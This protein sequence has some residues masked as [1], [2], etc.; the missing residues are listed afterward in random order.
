VRIHHLRVQ[1]FGPFA[2]EVE[3]DLD[4]LSDAGLFLL[5]GA[6]GAGK[7]SVLD[8]VC[9]ALYGAVPG[10]RQ[11]AKR[12][13]SD[14]AAPGVAPEVS[15][16]LTV[17]GRRFRIDRSAAWERPKKRGT[18]TT[19]EQ[20][21]VLVQERVGGDWRPLATRLDDAGH[22]VT[23]LLG[24][25][26]GQFCQV[27][28]LPQGRFQAFLRAGSEERHRL[29][30]Q[31][32]R[33]TRFE[34]VEA[35]LRD[36][37]RTLHRASARHHEQ[38]ADLVSRVSEVSGSPLP[39][40]WDLH[41]LSP[42]ADRVG[43]WAAD[44][45]ASSGTA[46]DA[47]A[48]RLQRVSD[49]ECTAR[50]QL[51]EARALAQQ[52]ARVARAVTQREALAEEAGAHGARVGRLDAGRRA[53]AVLPHL[54][55]AR[56][57]EA[58]RDR[59]ES[60]AASA[61]ADAV[62]AL[63][64][65]H[66][67]PDTALLA[68]EEQQAAEGAARARAHQPRVAEHARLLAAIAADEVRAGEVAEALATLEREAESLPDELT[69]RRT[70]EAEGRRAADGVDA[71]RRE[72]AA[73]REQHEAAVLV[74]EL[75]GRRAELTALHQASV[76]H[77]QEQRE[78]WLEL[79]E[80]R[81]TGMAAEIAGGLAVGACCPVCGSDD[82]PHRA[83]P[84]PGAPDADAV[85]DARRR[86]DD[87]EV[88]RQA[89][90]MAVSDLAAQVTAARE[91]AGHL[92]VPVLER[93]VAD[94]EARLGRLLERAAR[95]PADTA[96]R[97]H[98]EQQLER[99]AARRT[100]LASELAAVTAAAEERRARATVLEADLADLLDGSGHD[101]VESLAESLSRLAATCASAREAIVE[102]QRRRDDAAT[103][104]VNARQA[105]DAHGFDDPDDA[106]TAAV[107][108]ADLAALQR[109][110]DDHRARLAAVESVLADPALQQA[111][112]APHP[113]L[114][115]LAARH[116]RHAEDLARA[117]DDA[118]SAAR[119]QE[120]LARLHADLDAALTAWAPVRADHEL[121]DR[122]ATL[123]DGTSPDNRLRMR[124]SG[125]VLAF[126]LRQVVAAANERL[127]TMTES[128]YRLEHSG[129]RG[130]G[131]SRG[132]L[133]LRVRDDWSGEAR[134]PVT[135][136]GGET[137][138]VSLAL[139][140]GLADVIAHEAGGTELDTLFVD[141]GF[142]TLDADSLDHVMDMLDT[143]RDG[144]RVVGVVSHVAEL[145]DRIPTQLHVR[146]HRSGSTLHQE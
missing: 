34:Q 76:D 126:R 109:A 95:L 30:Q 45:A 60:V 17:Q 141:E 105:A 48:D 97:E 100:E 124:L 120:R 112:R 137:F 79:Q 130:A 110:V 83:Q 122:L 21:S 58:A 28:L 128:R 59:A 85:R 84:L 101:S 47:A 64:P 24:M 67:E 136:S 22:L 44:L 108:P 31:L 33:T 129:D 87:A 32:F 80:R 61:V 125:Y 140:L 36:R 56:R 90:A 20:P 11:I 13:R 92:T 7:T 96:A 143:L 134:D 19:V 74:V 63:G 23:G 91:R 142:G 43:P 16:E 102:R 5:T 75:V 88:E 51:E 2:G 81:L 77:A 57:A 55:A 37:R 86:V 18:G 68:R 50:L 4:A 116:E 115:A 54:E 15:M 121:T 42:V 132:G 26:L 107:A 117:R 70:T 40:D 46:H 71:A 41:A 25:N 133:S 62:A 49:A 6:T 144:G 111:A 131:E 106:A 104:A 94:R 138:V 38:V 52:Q 145:R 82:H 114:E 39:D 72:V 146:K 119:Q 66:A 69:R 93:E 10:D 98:L 123:A 89:R 8:A 12:L 99:I 9:F 53:A 14:Q 103:T 73:V 27:Q 118:A 65:T 135:L 113:D 1:A 3:V 127:V 35:W 78:A 29:L 139:A